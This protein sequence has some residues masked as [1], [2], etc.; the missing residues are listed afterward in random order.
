MSKERKRPQEAHTSLG[1]ELGKVP[2]Q[3]VDVEAAVLGAILVEGAAMD[4]VC[5]IITTPEVFYRHYHQLIF[6]AAYSLYLESQPVDVFTVVQQLKSTNQLEEVG[7]AKYLSKLTLQVGSAAHVRSHA[8]IVF[9]RFMERELIRFGSQLISLGFDPEEDV[10]DKM[11]QAE[12]FNI[13]LSETWSGKMDVSSIGYIVDE[14]LKDTYTRVQNANNNITT[15]IYTGL[16]ELDRKTNGWQGGDLI[17]EAARPGMG[18]TAVAL[19]HAKCAA[20]HG[21]PTVFFSLEMSKIRITNRL[22]LSECNIDPERFKSGRLSG[23]E[24]KLVEEAGNRIAKLPIY[25]DDSPDNTMSQIRAKARTLHK[26]GKCQL[27]IIDYLQLCSERGVGGRNREQE[28]SAM[29]REAKKMAKELDIPV[30]LLSQLNRAVEE[31]GNKIPQLS[32]LRESGAIEQDADAI[33]FIYRPGYYGIEAVDADGR[34]TGKNY[35]ELLIRKNREGSLGTISFTHSDDL[36][37]IYDYGQTPNQNSGAGMEE[38]FL[39]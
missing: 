17:V 3:A 37:K 26:Q 9:E 12:A 33:I 25:I 7:G 22:I 13:A 10:Q 32:D 6:Q 27:V 16:H 30:I 4:E 11:D 1:Q 34:P 31:R 36:S 15:G 20:I 24:I 5:S 18:K 14:A 29:S 21:T 2:P 19:Q 39:F 38:N 23:E 8:Q 28:V 35:G